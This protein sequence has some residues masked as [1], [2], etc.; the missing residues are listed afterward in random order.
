MKGYDAFAGVIKSG[1]KTRRAAKMVILNHD[2][3]DIIEFVESK[4]KEE[5]KAKALIAQGYD[6]SFNGEA[7]SSIFFQN[8]NHSVRVTDEFM[9]AFQNDD[10]FSTRAVTTGEDIQSMPAKELMDKISSAAWETG[11]PGLQFDSTINDW[12]TCINT[13]RIHASNPCSEYMFLN[14]TACNLSSLNLMTFRDENGDF[15][16]EAFRRAI[17]VVITAMEIIVDNASYPSEKIKHNS[18]LFRTL[19]LGYANLGALLMSRGLSY[20][21]DDGRAYAAAITALMH[22][23]AYRTSSEIASY[24]G[25]FAEFK[26]NRRPMLRVIRK[27]ANAVDRIDHDRVPGF[28]MDTVRDVYDELLVRG[29]RDGFRNAQVTVLAPTGTIAFMMDCDTTG[30]EPDIALV[31][32][33]KLVGGGLLK[34]VNRTVPEALRRLGYDSQSIKRIVDYIDANDT[35]EGAPGIKDEH[36]PVFDCAFK[37][38][39][40]QRAIQYMGHVRMMAAVQPFLSGA[41]SKTV[42]MPNHATADEI[43]QTY[44]QAWQMGLKAI[45][46]YRDGCKASQPLNTSNEEQS[47]E[48]TEKKEAKPAKRMLRH[49]LPDE[50]ASITHKFT[51]GGHEGYITVGMYENGQPGEIFIVMSKEGSAVSGLM[52]SFATSISLALQ[53]GVP[54]KVLVRKFIHTRFE[55]SGFTNN[56]AIPIAKSVMDY[57]FRWLALKFMPAEEHGLSDVS[58]SEDQVAEVTTAPP[59]ENRKTVETTAA[60]PKSNG[61]GSSKADTTRGPAASVSRSVSTQGA[62]PG[63]HMLEKEAENFVMTIA[64]QKESAS[65]LIETDAPPCPEC[66]AITTRSGSCYRCNNCGATTG[67]S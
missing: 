7:Y 54:L 15:D 28:I 12:H 24:M 13:D 34:I 4:V 30:I 39:K 14:D 5:Q 56:P 37:P 6:S 43:A 59:A 60:P 55:P 50:R 25:P 11:D 21:S 33:K 63:G 26:K 41:I 66:G 27:H 48:S 20:D 2:H 16:V 1:G 44:A 45:A 23:E 9:Q 22:G 51:V 8:A 38:Y 35:I 3:P 31:K 47:A 32:Y 58:D 62:T 17:R 53:Y 61:N 42:N 57:I 29:E 65:G 49:K 40:G 10:M 18:H 19:G 67:C 46:I 36:L 64:D 52:D